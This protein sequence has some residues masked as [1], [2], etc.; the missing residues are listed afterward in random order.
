[1]SYFNRETIES[2]RRSGCSDG[3]SW[4]GLNIRDLNSGRGPPRKD[5]FF[6]FG[7]MRRAMQCAI[8][9]EAKGYR[10]AHQSATGSAWDPECNENQD[11]GTRPF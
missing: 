9:N 3:G 1:M 7:I 10:T 4:I 11:G 8:Y 2:R 6:F 5:G